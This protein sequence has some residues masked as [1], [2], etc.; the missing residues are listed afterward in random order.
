MFLTERE[1][2]DVHPAPHGDAGQQRT[3][4]IPLDLPSAGEMRHE[5]AFG[6]AGPHEPDRDTAVRGMREQHGEGYGEGAIGQPT[7]HPE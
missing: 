3:Q 7:V 2:A 6:A 1:T 4:R 5:L